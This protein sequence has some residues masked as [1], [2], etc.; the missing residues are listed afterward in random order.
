MDPPQWT[1]NLWDHRGVT[2]KPLNS[3]AA[4]M[5]GFLHE[6]PMTGWDLIAT[7]QYR[8]GEFWT[9]TR[10]Q[11]YRELATL[12]DRG[13]IVGLESGARERKPYEIT[14]SGRTAFAAWIH[15][16]PDAGTIRNPM[17]LTLAFGAHLEP[18][19]LATMLAT[20]RREHEAVLVGYRAQAVNPE[21]IKHPFAA[22]TL[23]FGITYEEGVLKWFDRLPAILDNIA[24]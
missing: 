13:L 9:I 23:E 17:L 5:L 24:P 7:A 10:S 3:T 6:G 2:D 20:H 14:E 1:V 4:S 12:A 22:A 8:I 19:V 15:R 16:Q 18:T 11:V 21:I